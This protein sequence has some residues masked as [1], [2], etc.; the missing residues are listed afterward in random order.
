MEN[1]D[2]FTEAAAVDGK[3]QH[4]VQGDLKSPPE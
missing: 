4:R 2:N 1:G 3:L